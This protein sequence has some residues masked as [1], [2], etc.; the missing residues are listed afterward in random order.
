[1][2]EKNKVGPQDALL[3]K[4]PSSLWHPGHRCSA[5]QNWSIS[6]PGGA[7]DCPVSGFKL[8]SQVSLKHLSLRFRGSLHPLECY[9]Q[10]CG[11]VH[12]SGMGPSFHSGLAVPPK[13]RVGAG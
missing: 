13:V 7:S 2:V 8:G 10:C 5:A 11:F 1:M 6:G 4:P 9:A 12:F 3:M